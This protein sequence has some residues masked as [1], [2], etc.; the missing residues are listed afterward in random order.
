M[1]SKI[2][3]NMVGLMMKK[4]IIDDDITIKNWDELAQ[5]Q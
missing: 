1:I 4:M 5:D 2:P 3:P